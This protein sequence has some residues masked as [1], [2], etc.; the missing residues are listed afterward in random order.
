MRRRKVIPVVGEELLQVE[1]EDKTVPL[2]AWMAERLASVLEVLS[3]ELPSPVSLNDVACRY[4]ARNDS[5]RNSIYTR[6]SIIVDEANAYLRAPMALRQLAEITDFNLFL[7]TSFD[8]LMESVVNEIR[9]NRK[10]VSLAW[11][12]RDAAEKFP[13]TNG[14]R[15][16]S[17]R[18]PQTAAAPR[19]TSRSKPRSQFSITFSLLPTRSPSAGP[20]VRA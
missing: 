7:T 14:D 17:M 3:S 9:R 6:L 8:S 1:I 4:L 15:G 16:S 13:A 11:V 10:K 12:V 2:Y 5:N 18:K 19:I 20:Q